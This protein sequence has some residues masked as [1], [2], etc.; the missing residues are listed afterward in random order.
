MNLLITNTQE[1]QPYLILRCLRHV[2]DR[3][4]VTVSEGNLFKRW[5]GIP[6]WSRH[7]SKRYTAPDCSADWRAGRIQAGNTPA[8][9][10]YIRRIEEICAKEHID[11]I[12]PSYD[13]E[14]YVFAKNKARMAAQGIVTVVPEY[15]T[16]TRILD[17]DLTL[18][19]A[20]AA[21]FPIPATRVPGNRAELLA[22]AAELAPPWVLKPRCNA[23]GANIRL[24][25]DLDELEAIFNELSE[26]QPRPLLQEYVPALTKRSY[27]LVVSPRFE[28]VALYSP[29]VLRYRKIGMR[30]P[31]AVVETTSNVPLVEEILALVR[32]LGIWGGMTAQTIVD[33]RDG[34]PRL[35]EINPRFGHNLWYRTEFGVNEPLMYLRL[36]QG[37]PVGE[38]PT[39]PDGVLL[40]D[41][42]WDILHLLGLCVD[43]AKHW[44]RKRF[45][46]AGYDASTFDAESIPRLLRDYKSEYFSR[47]PRVTNPLNRGWLSDPLPPLIRI[48]RTILYELIR[49]RTVARKLSQQ[50]PEHTGVKTDTKQ[51]HE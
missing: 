22:G 32:K 29:Q 49:R 43:Q 8:E 51:H 10:N 28:V 13:A 40:L 34:I 46:T 9:E 17:K 2:A 24:A 33:A 45:R 27:Y 31:S 3:V 44:L 48:S 19:A 26:I 5:S 36:A 6:A 35:M 21:G 47:R 16:L 42:L 50:R 7:V 30:T 23:H 15:E 1:E 11:V 25:R 4:V 12:F 38:V 41:P 14:V 39:L 20:L 37:Q 18:K